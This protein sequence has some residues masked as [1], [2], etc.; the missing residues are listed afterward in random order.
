MCL[1]EVKVIRLKP[2]FLDSQPTDMIRV[3][4]SRLQRAQ[5]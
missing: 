3:P 1:P 4:N 5:T 2:S